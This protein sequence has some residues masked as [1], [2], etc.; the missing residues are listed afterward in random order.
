[1][2]NTLKTIEATPDA[3]GTADQAKR[4]ITKAKGLDK[5][6]RSVHYEII[7]LLEEGFGNLEKEREVLDKHEDDLSATVIHI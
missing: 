1:M 6:F 2:V 3:P 7:N 5:D 4:F